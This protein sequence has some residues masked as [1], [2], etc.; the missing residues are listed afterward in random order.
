VLLAGGAYVVLNEV[1]DLPPCIVEVLNECSYKLQILNAFLESTGT[2]L[3]QQGRQTCEL[4]YS[5]SCKETR[6]CES[7]IEENLAL[8]SKLL[9]LQIS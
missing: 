7:M 1:H 3:L 9:N 5:E 6:A 8:F 4:T 2:T